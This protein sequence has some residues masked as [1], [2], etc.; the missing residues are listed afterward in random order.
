MTD[1]TA[2]SFIKITKST[3]QKTV[4]QDYFRTGDLCIAVCSD[5]N[6]NASINSKIVNILNTAKNSVVFPVDSHTVGA[7]HPKIQTWTN[8]LLLILTSLHVNMNEDKLQLVILM[9]V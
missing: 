8:S 1:Q 6:L 2:E 4:T 9:P 7:C 5:S 3:E